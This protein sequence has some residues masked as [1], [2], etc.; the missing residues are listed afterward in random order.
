MNEHGTPSR[1]TGAPAPFAGLTPD[2][3]MQAA[4]AL[5]IE[6]DGRLFALNSYENRVYRVGRFD[7]AP[8]VIKFYR[9]ARWSDQQILEEHAFAL[10]LAAQ[11]MPVARAA[12]VERLDAASIRRIPAGRIH[13]LRRHGAGTR[14]TRGAR[15]ARSHA[16]SNACG[17]RAA[18]ISVSGVRWS[19]NNWASGH[20]AVCCAPTL[21]PDHMRQRYGEV[22]AELLRK[23]SEALR[24]GGAD[25]LDPPAR[26]LPSRQHFVAAAWT[27]AGRSGRLP[28]RSA[29]PGS[30]D[31]S[32]RQRR[33]AA[34][35]MERNRGRVQPIR[36]SRLQ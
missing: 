4:E 3:V 21:L 10:E 34:A 22:S 33:R 2:V 24:A 20:G 29:H 26:R 27:A 32:F 1:L 28:Q 12:G 11:E 8:V 35:P 6:P 14:C 18:P 15:V 9:A 13:A 16:G 25:R 19:G 30:V 5:G 23:I 7:A 31:V 17:R 36:R